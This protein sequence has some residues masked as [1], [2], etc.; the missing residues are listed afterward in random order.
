MSTAP[1]I[2]RALMARLFG[3]ATP[4]MPE[5]AK[6]APALDG[7]AAVAQRVGRRDAQLAGWDQDEARLLYPGFSVGPEDL[8]L[9]A[10]SDLPDPATFCRH[11]GARVIPEAADGA[12]SRVYCLDRLQR[13]EDPAAAL[14]ALVR[15]GR[16]GARFLL[17]VPDP[18]QE[19]LVRELA[20]AGLFG[21][22]PPDAIIR[23]V[24]AGNRHSFA[25]DGFARLVADAGLVAETQRGDGF[26]WAMYYILFWSSDAD[27]AAPAHPALENW[28]RTWDA[29][30][31][32]PQ[33][34]RLKRLMDEFMPRSQII[35]A[36]KP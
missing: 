12:A 16:P 26:Y 1:S 6:T 20:P 23:G 7:S 21:P 2:L 34:P 28:T 36:R 29:V 5:Q 19:K 22:A 35:L 24:A 11:H 32:A 27:L 31:D 3:Q 13:A 15:I 33:G 25:R 17:S 14:A 10:G 4:P 9:D 8:V 18:V 30:L